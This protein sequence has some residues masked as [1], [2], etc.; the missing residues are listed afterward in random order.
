MSMGLIMCDERS[1][2]Q[3]KSTQQ[4]EGQLPP[5]CSFFFSFPLI[6]CT[7]HFDTALTL[8]ANHLAVR[9]YACDTQKREHLSTDCD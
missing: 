2:R 8:Q 5:P 6:Y 7:L 1:Y 9:S 3:V 4:A